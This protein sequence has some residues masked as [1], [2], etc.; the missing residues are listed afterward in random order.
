VTKTELF[1]TI[2]RQFPGMKASDVKKIVA[3]TVDELATDLRDAMWTGVEADALTR[4]DLNPKAISPTHKLRGELARSV[5]FK[6]ALME[7][8]YK[9][10]GRK[11]LPWRELK[12]NRTK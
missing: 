1:K 6:A 12:K 10:P 5:I 2:G 11:K 9:K 4:R 3:A 7:L 8:A